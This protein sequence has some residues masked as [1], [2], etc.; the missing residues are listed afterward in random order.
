MNWFLHEWSI[1]A[2]S[3]YNR[4]NGYWEIIDAKPPFKIGQMLHVE[5]AVGGFHFHIINEKDEFI[6][7]DW[8]TIERERYVNNEDSDYGWIDLDGNF[9]GCEY[10]EHDH[11]LYMISGLSELEAERMGWIKIYRDPILAEWYPNKLN[12]QGMIYYYDERSHRLNKAQKDTLLI[13][14]F[15]IEDN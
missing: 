8:R 14:G 7:S 4:Y 9:Y 6:Q 10:E 5:N 3:A 2:N 12:N 15:K 13:H 1:Y 11:C